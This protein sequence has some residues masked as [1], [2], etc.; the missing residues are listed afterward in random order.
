M[1]KH[2]SVQNLET[3][4]NAKRFRPQVDRKDTYEHTID[5]NTGCV[6]RLGLRDRPISI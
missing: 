4:Q 5:I 6:R 2:S 1:F 3:Q